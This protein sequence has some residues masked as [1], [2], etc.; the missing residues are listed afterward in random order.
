MSIYK[1]LRGIIQVTGEK[2][3]GKT[4]FAL[5]CGIDPKKMVFFQDDVK[6]T[7]INPKDF[8]RFIDV[9]TDFE[10]VTTLKLR[11]KLKEIIDGI[12]PNQYEVCIFDTWAKLGDALRLWGKENATKFREASTFSSMGKIRSGEEWQIGSRY[13]AD[14]LAEVAK[15]FRLVFIVSH[16]KEQM[17]AGAKTDKMIPESHAAIE[18]I[19]LFRVWLRQNE[20]GSPVPIALIPKRLNKRVTDKGRIRTVNVLPRRV[21]PLPDE[22]SLWDSFERY[23]NEPMGNREPFPKE[24]PNEFEVSILDGILTADQKTVWKANLQAVQTEERME[25]FSLGIAPNLIEDKIKLIS[26]ELQV[27]GGNGWDYGVIQRRLDEEIP[28]HGYDLVK[29]IGV[30]SK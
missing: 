30:M 8:G 21:E 14:F 17:K 1:Q 13:E 11:D 3:I 27:N 25:Q 20:T 19:C 16:L 29:I 6:D 4:T 23:W 12:E 22:L 2:G 24:L 9:R 28:N 18:T 7:G 5:E 10:G 15:K 26:Q